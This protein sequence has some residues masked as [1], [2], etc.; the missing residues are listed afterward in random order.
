MGPVVRQEEIRRKPAMLLQVL[1]LKIR[2][3]TL[4]TENDLLNL[5]N[6]SNNGF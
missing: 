5:P 2:L 3:R 1:S 4:F 6:L